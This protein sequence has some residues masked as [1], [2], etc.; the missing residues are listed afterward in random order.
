M[1]D[2]K[3]DM[4]ENVSFSLNVSKTE[5]EKRRVFGWASVSL[6]VEGNLVEDLQKTVIPPEVLEEAVYIYIL[7]ERN[8]GDMHVATEGVGKC[9]ESMVFTPEKLALLGI[10][11]SNLHQCAWWF[12]VQF[13]ESDE[14]NAA[15][16]AVKNGKRPML[17]I[18]GVAEVE[19]LDESA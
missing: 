10:E 5:D 6:D 14:G 7:E 9:I 13:D 15:W 12:G 11:K 8:G 3:G 16:Q 17:S 19:L 18:G 2:I 1:D 4:G